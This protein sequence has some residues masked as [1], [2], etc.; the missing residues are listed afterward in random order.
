MFFFKGSSD[1]VLMHKDEMKL[2]ITATL[3]RTKHNCVRGL[4]IEF[5]EI[6]SRHISQQ[7]DITSSTVL[8]ILEG[9]LVLYHNLSVLE[10]E[11]FL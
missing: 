9:N 11:W 3:V 2:G 7:F 5:S 6:K 10:L 4:V 1:R 8:T